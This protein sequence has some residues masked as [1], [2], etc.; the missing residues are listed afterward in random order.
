MD[1]I[2]KRETIYALEAAL[3]NLSYDGVDVSPDFEAGFNAATKEVETVPSPW[4]PIEQK[5]LPAYSKTPHQ[6]G[7]YLVTYHPKLTSGEICKTSVVGIDHFGRN[8][9]RYRHMREVT[10]W[11]ELPDMPDG[12]PPCIYS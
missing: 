8:G 5:Q 4:I 7:T 12:L 9:W 6:Y 1:L 2:S 3:K 11:M 10:H